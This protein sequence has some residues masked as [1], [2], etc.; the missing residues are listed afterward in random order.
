MEHGSYETDL[1]IEETDNLGYST[2][3]TLETHFY[4]IVGHLGPQIDGWQ[5]AQYLAY[6]WRDH[7]GA[8]LVFTFPNCKTMGIRRVHLRRGLNGDASH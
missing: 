1:K 6:Y 7:F 8:P 4:G 2:I 3:K 5:T